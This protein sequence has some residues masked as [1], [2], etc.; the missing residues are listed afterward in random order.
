MAKNKWKK[1]YK[2]LS[3]A[4]QFKAIYTEIY[5]LRRSLNEEI[6]N[7]RGEIEKQ[8]ERFCRKNMDSDA[9]SHERIDDEVKSL[10]T[11]IEELKRRLDEAI[12]TP[13]PVCCCD[14]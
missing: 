10:N 1:K 13:K 11:N 14:N 7:I 2:K 5:E 12:P 3:M 6:E 9:F 4:N 8:E